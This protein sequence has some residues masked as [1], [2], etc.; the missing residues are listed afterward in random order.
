MTQKP[1]A[2]AVDF[3]VAQMTGWKTFGGRGLPE[4][5]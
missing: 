5:T 1:E 2:L 4:T 3:A